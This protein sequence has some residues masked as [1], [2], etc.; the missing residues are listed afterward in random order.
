[1]MN[2]RSFLRR[3]GAG[4]IGWAG[5]AS[6]VSCRTPGA[7]PAVA[8]RNWIWTGVNA[9]ASEAEQRRRFGEFREAGI[10][11]VLFGGVDERVFALA[12]E[13]GL[14]SHAWIWTLCRGSRE[15]RREHPEWYCVSREG[16]STADHPPYVGYYRFLCPSRDGV[17]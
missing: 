13:H 4:A 11:G 14:E 6:G 10:D 2:R 1:M 8:T 12:R 15:L 3:A 7:G 5:V 16:R 17:R 9:D